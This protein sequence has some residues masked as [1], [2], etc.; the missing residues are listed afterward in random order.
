MAIE[1]EPWGPLISAALANEK[2]KS[3]PSLSAAT[4]LRRSEESPFASDLIAKLSR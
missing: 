2:S 3:A 1:D 4:N